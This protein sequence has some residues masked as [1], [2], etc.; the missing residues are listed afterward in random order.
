MRHKFINIGMAILLSLGTVGISHAQIRQQK[1]ANKEVEGY[2]YSKAI[3]NYLRIIEKDKANAQVYMNLGDAYYFNAKLDQAFVWYDKYFQM[4]DNSTISPDHFFRYG[5]SLKAVGENQK[6]E[7]IL[8]IWQE[9]LASSTNGNFVQEE[10]SDATSKQK[11]ELQLLLVNGKFADYAAVA[12][13][14]KIVFTSSRNDEDQ[15]K[16]I[17]PWTNEPYTSLFELNNQGSTMAKPLEFEGGSKE[18]NYSSSSFS[19]DGNTMF[20]TANNNNLRGRKKFNKKSSSLLKIFRATKLPDGTWGR[21]LELSINSDNFNT[22]HPSVSIDGKVLYFTSDRPGGYGESDIYKVNLQDFTPVGEVENLGPIINT[23]GR[24]T[25]PFISSEQLYF[26]SDTHRGFGGLDIFSSTLVK[27]S[28]WGNVQN[29]GSMYNSSF[30]DFAYFSQAKGVGFLSSNRPTNDYQNDNIYSFKICLTQLSGTIKDE[31][32]LENIAKGSLKFYLSDNSLF[33]ELVSDQ[34]GDYYTDLLGCD[35]NYTV[36]IQADGYSPK[37]I[38]VNLSSNNPKENVDVFLASIETQPLWQPPSIEPI[39]FDFDQVKITEQSKKSLSEI[40]DV[41]ES[42]PQSKVVITSHT[43]SRGSQNYNME[44]SKKR[45]QQT[46]QWL[47]N[48]GVDSDR[49]STKWKGEQELVNKCKDGVPCSLEQHALNRRSEFE[50][51]EQ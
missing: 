26:S 27:D 49:I 46:A 35:Q 32:T 34:N 48:S 20:F 5:Q 30:D 4:Q 22:A 37:T 16:K 25:Y 42:Y 50:L 15:S 45:A 12:T 24:E 14:N 19:A 33:Q 3:A 41:L 51:L 6:A 23:P 18:V 44:L 1:I 39:Y 43:D 11:V 38:S 36:S 47:I 17:D 10:L 7:Q 31:K 2:A 29:L 8:A 13:Q 21:V 40:H 28:Q 9:S